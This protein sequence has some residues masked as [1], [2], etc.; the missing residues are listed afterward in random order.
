MLK[1]TEWPERAVC[2]LDDKC[3]LLALRS[4]RQR[5]APRCGQERW[6]EVGPMATEIWGK[7]EEEKTDLLELGWSG[8][9]ELGMNRGTSEGE[10]DQKRL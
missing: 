6:L 8:E 3:G 4:H 2:T 5:K 10:G 7:K 9:E 1:L